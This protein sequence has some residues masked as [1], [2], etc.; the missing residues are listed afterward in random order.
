VLPSE[1]EKE[2]EIYSFIGLYSPSGNKINLVYVRKTFE[3]VDN[4]KVRIFIR[5]SKP[6]I[7][8]QKFNSGVQG[9]DNGNNTVDYKGNDD[10]N[11]RILDVVF[12]YNTTEDRITF[13][14]IRN[15]I[16]NSHTQ[17]CFNKSID[18][19]TSTE[20]ATIG[21]KFTKTMNSFDVFVQNVCTMVTTSPGKKI[22]EM[23][24]SESNLN[25]DMSFIPIYP[26]KSKKSLIEASMKEYGCYNIELL[27]KERNIDSYISDT[28][29]NPDPYFD[30]NSINENEKFGRVYEDYLEEYD[31]TFKVVENESINSNIEG[32]CVN[33]GTSVK[34]YE[35]AFGVG[36]IEDGEIDNFKIL[37]FNKNTLGKNPFYFG[38]LTSLVTATQA[39]YTRYIDTSN[40]ANTISGYHEY[41]VVGTN[42]LNRTESSNIE[43]NTIYNISNIRF[44]FDTGKRQ[45]ITVFEKEDPY[46]DSSINK[47]TV[48][49]VLFN[50][51]DIRV[52]E[53]YHLFDQYGLINMRYANDEYLFR[54]GGEYGGYKI[55]YDT[56]RYS[57]D[58]L[59]RRTKAYYY[60]RLK[61]KDLQDIQLSDYDCLSDVYV[62]QD[63][64]RLAFKYSDQDVF[65]ISALSYYFPTLNTKYPYT[66]GQLIAQHVKAIGASNEDGSG[67][68]DIFDDSNVYIINLEETKD[69]LGDIGDIDIPRTYSPND[70]IMA[71][72][73]YLGD[74]YNTRVDYYDARAVQYF[75]FDSLSASDIFSGDGTE[76]SDLGITTTGKTSEEVLR[77][78]S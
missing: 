59:K 77:E 78:L 17:K 62:F 35:W 8:I 74:N 56:S 43:N 20:G 4:G 57:E 54:N 48:K 34:A 76:L 52:F 39:D 44:R 49:Y 50:T 69:I 27:G 38:D 32:Y 22:T 67:I 37:I 15:L 2:R 65:H 64:N 25:A 45:I 14:Y 36:D 55:V 63:Y 10:D 24:Y 13:C 11:Q 12:S 1:L 66:T 73:E 26:D 61:R 29:P 19:Q 70:C 23:S 41:N 7:K 60:E 58:Y 72:E 53:Y 21:D 51:K 68:Y 47:G 46:I 5:G 75:M 42:R 9:L 31:R 18:M 16:D 71:F 33:N 30:V 28:N 6:F 40:T 3:Y